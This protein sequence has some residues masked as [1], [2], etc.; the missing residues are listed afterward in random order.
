M[1]RKR[2]L[3]LLM[4]WILS[5]L[6]VTVDAQPPLVMFWKCFWEVLQDASKQKI[7]APAITGKVLWVQD[8]KV[9]IMLPGGAEKGSLLDVQRAFDVVDSPETIYRTIAQL[10]V[11]ESYDPLLLAFAPRLRVHVPIRPGDLVK[12]TTPS[13]ISE[14]QEAEEQKIPEAT[15]LESPP[16]EEQQQAES[17]AGNSAFVVLVDGKNIYLDRSDLT[18]DT[19][20][21][22]MKADGSKVT[23]TVREVM[24][25]M[26]KVVLT[27]A[28][29]LRRGE[30][31]EL[32]FPDPG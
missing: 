18:V 32:V 23:A 26:S 19:I 9:M 27:D 29:P 16:R 13:H 10:L 2:S 6:P 5:S 14:K 17:P 24:P 8:Q 21:E 4:I 3:L 11:T 12:R 7:Q 31:V 30:E 20:I 15:Q 25:N 1:F 22:I 28:F